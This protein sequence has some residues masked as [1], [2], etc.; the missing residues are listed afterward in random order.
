[1]KK[2]VFAKGICAK[3]LWIIFIIGSIF[4]CYFEMIKNFFECLI[5][6]GTIFW[7]RRSGVIY[8]P[9]SVIYGFGAV[10]ITIF[11]VNKKYKD[12]KIVLLGGLMCGFAEYLI[13]FL[14]ET[15]IGTISW[16]YSDQILNIN[17][18][19]TIPI[20]FCWGLICFLF[21]R[22]IYPFISNL[23]EKIPYKQGTIALYT[24]VTLLII[25]MFIS[26]TALFRQFLRQKDVK[27]L[28]FY[29]EFLDKTYPD[30]RLKK[31]FPNMEFVSE[32]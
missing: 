28:T 24:L 1:M 14:Q 21:V 13:N 32:D 9:F 19:T 31:A 29:G 20:M 5:A 27:P 16:D 6:T 17:G 8:G 26:Y 2:E 4:G 15:F 18:R 10:L 7:E 22:Y 25:D 23:V 3:K 12:I 30:E 11:F